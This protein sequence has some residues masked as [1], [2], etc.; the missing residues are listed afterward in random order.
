MDTQI[1]PAKPFMLT[2]KNSNLQPFTMNV[3]TNNKLLYFF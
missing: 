3:T 2:L 1:K